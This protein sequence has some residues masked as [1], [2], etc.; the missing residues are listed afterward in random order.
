MIGTW[1]N[2]TYI[3]NRCTR[4][5]VAPGYV[6]SKGVADMNILT[7]KICG[8]YKI[9]NLI[10]GKVYIGQSRDI[11][12]RW[13]DHR[14]KSPYLSNIYLHRAIRKHGIENFRFEVLE[15][16]RIDQLN[17]LERKYI[18][19]YKSLKPNGYNLDLGGGA[20]KEI[21]KETKEKLRLATTGEKNPNYGKPKSLLTRIKLALS[22]SPSVN[23][24]TLDGKFIRT[25]ET[26]V[27][28]VEAIV[29]ENTY[30]ARHSVCACCRGDRMAT[31][32][33]QWR[34]SSVGT[35]NIPPYI[36]SS[37]NRIAVDQFTVDGKYVATYQS[38]Q[39]AGKAVGRSN[40]NIIFACERGGTSGGYRWRYS[41]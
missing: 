35:S 41:K 13:I 28:A 1:Y 14:R 21:S 8:V 9:T 18:I 25:F 26:T 16:C 36:K 32:G 4:D 11:H 33:Y 29:G 19:R 20:G 3:L 17:D 38:A 7:R 40:A 6:T 24:Y 12:K 15:E 27:E 10:N 23:Q 39:Q 2:S 30:T 37:Y 31:L 34:W 5:V 22:H